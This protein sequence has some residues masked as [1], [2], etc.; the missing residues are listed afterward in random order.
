MGL[1]KELECSI[2]VTTAF[3]GVGAALQIQFQYNQNVSTYTPYSIG[4]ET[5]YIPVANLVLG[6]TFG[7]HIGRISPYPAYEFLRLVF[8][9]SGGPFTAGAVSAGIVLSVQ[10]GQNMNPSGF[11]IL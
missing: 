10:D 8:N 6:A 5:D 11:S 3:V 2:I 7:L 9:V 1:G 4:A